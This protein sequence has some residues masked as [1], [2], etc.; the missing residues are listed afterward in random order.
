MRPMRGVRKCVFAGIFAAV[1]GFFAALPSAGQVPGLGQPPVAPSSSGTAA[2]AAL[3]AHN[4]I[5]NR[6]V[7]RSF[8][9]SSFSG[10]GK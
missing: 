2:T 10:A 1:A 9:R 7:T 6:V 5:A 8:M 3:A 4:M